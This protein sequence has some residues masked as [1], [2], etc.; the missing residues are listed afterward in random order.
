MAG[1]LSHQRLLNK[2]LI[3]IREMFRSTLKTLAYLISAI[4][5]NITL[6][7]YSL[8]FMLILLAISLVLWETFRDA[9]VMLEPILVPQEFVDMGYT[10]EIMARR[11]NDSA[12]VYHIHEVTK[13]NDMIQL[14]KYRELDIVLPEVG[15]SIKSVSS[16][17]RDLIGRN[18]SSISGEMLYY[19]S[20]AQISFRL[21]FNSEQIYDDFE[22][23]SE[24]GITTL[25]NK[26]GYMLTKRVNP[27]A[28]A[29][30]HYNNDEE[31]KALEIVNYIFKNL[32][33]DKIDFV[34]AVN[35]KGVIHHLNDEYEEAISEYKWAIDL[36]PSYAVPYIN[37]GVSLMSKREPDYSGAIERFMKALKLDPNNAFAYLN[38]GVALM[39]KREPDWQGAIERFMEALKLDPN[40][41]SAHVNWG[42]ALMS[43]RE[44]DYSGAIERFM[45]AL[46]LDPNNVSAHVY[47]GIALMSKRELGNKGAIERFME[48]LKLD[49][50]NVS[51]HVYWGI[52]LMSK[53][54]LGNKGAIERF[55][56]A[57]KLDPNNVSAHVNW[58]VALMSKR[59]PDYSGAI[60][61]FIV[62][63]EIDPNY[64]HAHLNWGFA[65]MNKRGPD[66][67]GAI[68]KYKKVIKLA[69]MNTIAYSHMFTA[70]AYLGK[71]DIATKVLN[72]VNNI[73][74]SKMRLM[75]SELVLSL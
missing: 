9:G 69:P 40:N 74:D 3:C 70:L 41:V 27:F 39:K 11:L 50:N 68:E 6:V 45:E 5:R 44:P 73:G 62:A 57:L 37:W 61:R 25:L 75:C 10:P 43:K 7:F 17:F 12:N 1:K 20:K 23:L 71:Y 49:P 2:V 64:T 38:W 14:Y 28:L 33:K 60:E 31:I 35:L 59:E 26:A 42:V 53:R 16:Y 22:N 34:R 32:D 15:I 67:Y 24:K 55:M 30:Y 19:K 66:L 52:A 51:A 13:I 65:L 21:R 29:H 8:M 4:V 56:E 63:V 58:G 36:D 48:A 47:W 54:E 18:I 72:C 46:K